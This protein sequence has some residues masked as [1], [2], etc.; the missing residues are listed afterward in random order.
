[1]NN[2]H[3]LGEKEAINSKEQRKNITT[4]N[5]SKNIKDSFNV[6]DKNKKGNSNI[7]TRNANKNI[8]R[9]Q[10]FSSIINDDNYGYIEES[11][12]YNDSYDNKY[13]VQLD[14]ISKKA[15]FKKNIDHE[16][17]LKVIAAQKEKAEKDVEAAIEARKL[18]EAEVSLIQQAKEADAE[19]VR[20]KREELELMRF[21]NEITMKQLEAAHQMRLKQEKELYDQAMELEKIKYAGIVQAEK[22][23]ESKRREEK[24]AI[25]EEEKLTITKFFDEQ[26]TR[27]KR[28][29]EHK[30]E[31]EELKERREREKMKRV[32]EDQQVMLRVN[33][34]NNYLS[35]KYS[36]DINDLGKDTTEEFRLVMHEHITSEEDR[37][38]KHREKCFK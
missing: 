13:D 19:K 16:H 17:Q 12:A 35:A 6:N 37:L 5:N 31:M 25:I 1:L 32:Q 23:K 29:M 14:M 7:I 26:Y 18:K 4:A 2:L 30:H 20:L 33:R 9:S 36:R 38:Q 22:E 10:E 24:K 28:K 21:Q 15:F 3:C 34:E 11:N 27:Q 8:D